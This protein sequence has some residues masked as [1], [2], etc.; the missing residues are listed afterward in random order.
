MYCKNCGKEILKKVEVCPDCG[1][2]FG[3][4]VNSLYRTGII[5]TIISSVLL[6]LGLDVLESAIIEIIEVIISIIIII[7]GL[8][9]LKIKITRKYRMIYG[10]LLLALSL[11]LIYK[12]I[13]NNYFFCIQFLSITGVICLIGSILILI[14]SI[15]NNA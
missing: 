8:L 7:L 2:N 5:L 13:T 12:L 15:K 10:T 11:F 3:K 14:G 6:I 4:E 9:F 1:Y